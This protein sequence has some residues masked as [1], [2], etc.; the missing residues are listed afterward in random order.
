MLLSRCIRLDYQRFSFACLIDSYTSWLFNEP[1]SKQN[2]L[3]IELTEIGLDIG[4]L[5]CKKCHR[6]GGENG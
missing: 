4:L 3:I 5:R 1:S 6:S 2:F